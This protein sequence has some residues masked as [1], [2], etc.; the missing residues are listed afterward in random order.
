MDSPLNTT[1]Q[2]LNRIRLFSLIVFFLIHVIRALLLAGIILSIWSVILP[3]AEWEHFLLAALVF[4][5]VMFLGAKKH[6]KKIEGKDL[7]MAWE[8]KHQDTKHSPFTP[9]TFH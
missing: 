7:L 4:V 8:I 3:D 5:L 2:K 1:V 9:C 6:S